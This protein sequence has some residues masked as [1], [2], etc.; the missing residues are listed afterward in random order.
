MEVGRGF[1][2][3]EVD[4]TRLLTIEES[5]K[6]LENAAVSVRYDDRYYA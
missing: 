6:E 3:H 2:G 4:A 1:T 5:K